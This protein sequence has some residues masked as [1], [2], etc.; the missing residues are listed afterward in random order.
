MAKVCKVIIPVDE[1]DLLI[2]TL[3]WVLTATQPT[4]EDR[5][6][7]TDLLYRLIS[8][9]KIQIDINSSGPLN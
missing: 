6:K 1:L 3:K 4:D 2:S 7:L 9:K 5:K 8:A